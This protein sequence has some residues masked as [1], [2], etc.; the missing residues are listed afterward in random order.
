VKPHDQLPSRSLGSSPSIYTMSSS[1]IRVFVHWTEQTVFAG[2]DVECKIT[3]KNT[4]PVVGG[5][6]PNAQNTQTNGFT[7]GADRQRKAPWQGLAVGARGG[8]PLASKAPASPSRGQQLALS[9]S[10]PPS[11]SRRQASPAPFNTPPNGKAERRHKHHR[12]VSI[13]PMGSKAGLEE[14]KTNGLSPSGH[15]PPRGHARSAS[16]QIVPRGFVRLSGTGMTVGSQTH[17]G[18]V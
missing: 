18:Y 12:S 16:L 1:S 15:R 3:F 9:L 7:V 6:K 8:V 13:M 17:S 5:A 4:A 2:E 11:P 10:V 14:N